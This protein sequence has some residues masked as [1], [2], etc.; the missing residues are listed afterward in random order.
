MDTPTSWVLYRNG[1]DPAP[2]T[3]GA[4]CGDPILVHA[5]PRTR[6]ADSGQELVV[7]PVSGAGSARFRI[8]E[9]R[10]FY[11]VS[12]ATL[13]GGGLVV[14]VA[15]DGLTHAATLRCPKGAK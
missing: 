3:A 14:W 8:A 7:R 12:F 4:L 1:I 6:A 15:D 2:V 11:F 13:P 10:S 9:A 5:E